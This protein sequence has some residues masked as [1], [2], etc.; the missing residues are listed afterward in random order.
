M[1]GHGSRGHWWQLLPSLK[2]TFSHLKIDFWKRSFLLETTIFR[3][4]VSF[5]EGS[6]RAQWNLNELKCWQQSF[7]ATCYNCCNIITRGSLTPR[8]NQ[9]F[10]PS[11]IGFHSGW[12]LLS[13]SCL[14]SWDCRIHSFILKQTTQT[15]HGENCPAVCPLGSPGWPSVSFPMVARGRRTS[16]ACVQPCVAMRQGPLNI[17]LKEPSPSSQRKRWGLRGSSA[18]VWGMLWK[19]HYQA[20]V[21]FAGR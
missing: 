12:Y 1:R 13:C 19:W 21:S 10:I 8:K 11:L 3:C 16:S 7:F 15:R 20:V 17:H 6:C 4:Y 18:R 2:L 5:R 14:E 9:H